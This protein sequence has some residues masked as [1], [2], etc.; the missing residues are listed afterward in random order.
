MSQIF[1]GRTVLMKEAP[2]VYKQRA[3][4]SMLRLGLLRK[5]V[6]K[7]D[8]I[9]RFPEFAIFC[10]GSFGRLEASDY[11]DIDLFFLCGER[12]VDLEEPR[13]SE[14]RLFGDMIQIAD[15]LDFPKYSNDCEFL[16]VMHTS[17]MFDSLGSSKDDHGN[18]FTARMLMLLESK[19]V[20][21]EDAY[22]ALKE[23]II[24]SYFKDFP[25][26]KQTF[27]PIFLLNDICRFWKTL[28]LNY[29]SK[30]HV[31]PEDKTKHKVRNY[32]LKHSRMTTCFATIAALGS[33]NAPV[34]PEQVFEQTELTP[35]QRLL[36][37]ANRLPDLEKPVAK[38][39]DL[40]ARFLDKT[41]LPTVELEALFEDRS[42]TEALFRE[43][44]EYG[45]AMFSLLEAVDEVSG[46]D[47]RRLL[48]Y[49][50]I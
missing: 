13:T 37:I 40:Y 24:A 29:E 12:R 7:I 27:Q 33:F 38:V 45:D 6:Q 2:V 16:N 9:G 32:K 46:S 19:W 30:R 35:H 50:V 10:A 1:W 4:Y 43:A 14:L 31:K 22:K 26:H 15:R 41:G 39:V 49:L 28:L 34:T 36:G 25:D 18:F 23:E 3:D 5:E 48:R 42:K 8:V 17:D 44:A 11:S 21:G 47:D 20:Y